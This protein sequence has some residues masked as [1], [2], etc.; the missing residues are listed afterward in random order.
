MSDNALLEGQKIPVVDCYTMALARQFPNSNEMQ[1]IRDIVM[2][3]HF[4]RL[5]QVKPKEH[6]IELKPDLD[7]GDGWV[8]E[9]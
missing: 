3:N 7:I 5:A 1:L 8:R 9:N 6:E 2:N 4:E